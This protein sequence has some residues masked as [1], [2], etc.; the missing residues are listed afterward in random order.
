VPHILDRLDNGRLEATS[1]EWRSQFSRHKNQL[2]P[3]EYER[4]LAWA[5]GC[6]DY[7]GPACESFAY[8]V[9]EN[10]AGHAIA[11]SE[12][13]Y[14]K[15]GRKWLKLLDLHLCPAVDLSFYN[16]ELD[17]MG[18]S[19]IFA[20][21]IVGTFHLTKRHPTD[22][23]KLYGRSGTLLTFLKG[24]GAYIERQGG[25]PGLKVGIEGRWLVIR[26]AAA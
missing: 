17:I 10:G 6:V 24:I 22:T 7:E 25:L 16:D 12:V 23:V 11:I 4:I 21:A 19:S 1:N 20:A 18:L 2:I 13:V 15:S 5:A 14:S 3:S 26:G 8:G 9:Y